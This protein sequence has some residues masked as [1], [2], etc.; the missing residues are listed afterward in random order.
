MFG[1]MA[2][3]Q[4]T[5]VTTFE[6]KSGSQTK[7]VD[8]RH[9]VPANNPAT[10][11]TDG[12]GLPDQWEVANFGHL[13]VDPS[14]D[15]DGDGV[16]NLNEYKNGTDPN[17]YYNG[18]QIQLTIVGGNNQ[19]ANSGQFNSQPFEVMV[20]NGAGTVLLGNAPVTFTVIQG[21]G[22]LA[23]ANTNTSPLSTERTLRTTADGI[24]QIFY[25]QPSTPNVPSQIRAA[26][27]MA[28]AEF[29]TQSRA[30]VEAFYSTDFEA[31][32]GYTLGALSGQQG[33]VVYNNPADVTATDFYSGAQSVVLP[34]GT[35][36]SFVV[37]TLPTPSSASEPIVF[38]DFY[39]KLAAA[40]DLDSAVAFMTDSAWAVL[41][42]VGDRGEIYVF[43]GDGDQI[44]VGWMAT[45]FTVPLSA[46]NQTAQWLHLTVR[47]NFAAQI[48]DLYVNGRM[49]AANVLSNNGSAQQLT[50]FVITGHTTAAVYLDHLRASYDNPLFVDADKDG[51]DDA[52]EAAH[53]LDPT[54]NDRDLDSD[55]DGLTNSQEFMLGTAPDKADTDGDGMSDRWEVTHGLNPIDP[56]DAALDRDGNGQ[57]NLD[58]YRAATLLPPDAPGNL[59]IVSQTATQLTLAWDA[60]EPAPNR[61]IV[62]Y[63]VYL[64]GGKICSTPAL[65]SAVAYDPMGDSLQYY[66]VCAVDDDGRVSAPS[67]EI[68]AARASDPWNVDIQAKYASSG[69]TKNGGVALP[70]NRVFYADAYSL[71]ST[72]DEYSDQGQTG[73]FENHLSITEEYD[74]TNNQWNS[75][76]T[77]A[78]DGWRTKGNQIYDTGT[79]HSDWE[80]D[81]GNNQAIL[82]GED[83]VQDN[84]PL[85]SAHA[86]SFPNPQETDGPTGISI[87]GTYTD[88]GDVYLFPGVTFQ[89]TETSSVSYTKEYTDDQVV[90]KAMD[91]YRAAQGAV[92]GLPWPAWGWDVVANAEN[93]TVISAGAVQF[94]DGRPQYLASYQDDRNRQ[95]H[96]YSVG[97]QGAFYRLHTDNPGPVRFRWLEVFHPWHSEPDGPV[98]DGPPQSVLREETVAGGA[99]GAHTADYSLPP[100][101]SRGGIDI[102]VL[103]ADMVIQTPSMTPTVGAPRLFQ[104]NAI[105]VG[106]VAQI[107]AQ[108]VNWWNTATAGLALAGDMSCISL[109]VVDPQVV[110]SQ[111]MVAALAQGHQV[112]SGANLLTDSIWMN[113]GILAAVGL[114]PGTVDIAITLSIDGNSFPLHKTLSVYPKIE[115]AVDANRDGQ[116]KLSSEDDSDKTSADKPYRFWLN[117]DDDHGTSTTASLGEEHVPIVRPDYTANVISSQ[118]DLED[119]SRLWLEIRAISTALQPKADGTADLYIGLQWTSVTRGAPA[120]KLFRHLEPNG[121]TQYLTDP[122]VAQ[123]Q[124][125]GQAIIDAR[126]ASDDPASSSHSIVNGTATDITFFVLPSSVFANLAGA[127]SVVHFL[128]EGCSVGKGQLQVVILDKNMHIIGCGPGM[129]LDLANIRSMYERAIATA[130]NTVSANGIDCTIPFPHDYTG[131][132]NNDIPRPV[133]GWKAYDLGYPFQ[134]DPNE[135]LQR[136]T[137]VVF[138]HGWRKPP[139]DFVNMAETTFKRMWQSGYKGRFA[140]FRWPT[141]YDNF[142]LGGLFTYNDSEYRAWKCGESLKQYVNQLPSGYTRDV[143]AHSLG[144]IVV[145]SALQRG[146]S[147]ANY[148]L[149]NA[150]VPAMCYDESAELRW[151]TYTTPNDDPDPGTKALAYSGQFKMLNTNVVNFYLPLDSVAG[152][153]WDFNNRQ[154]K[155]QRYDG[156]LGYG[157][158][159]YAYD[160]SEPAGRRLSINFLFA[161]GRYLIDPHEA[162]P[163]AVQSLTRTVGVDG[164]TSGSVRWAVPLDTWNFG[165]QHSAE[166]DRNLQETALFYDEL[167]FRINIFTQ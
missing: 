65:T 55:N 91:G 130:D 118:R 28:Q 49:I 140:A 29:S 148:A 100:P 165:D 11:D 155:P 137:Y 95:G 101:S 158:T 103:S 30:A 79:F 87:T 78:Q 147:V 59:R 124:A 17:D 45:G 69:C 18:Q 74:P 53:G 41:K 8:L 141:F 93:G 38:C 32:E 77:G 68:A 70:Y 153:D 67:N 47:M 85:P 109:V 60:A 16:T 26:A 50:A 131:P 117:D 13:G 128:W 105:F 121:G 83:Y 102:T 66:S 46:N 75:V 125:F 12:N 96:L 120:I 15:P 145:G 116:I 151:W 72:Y 88:S 144:N 152:I 134:P 107:T 90:A 19:S 39:A 110:A 81:R 162:M 126:Y 4:T 112:A 82:V 21:G 25:K 98:D 1:V 136:K 27:A 40:Q 160:P 143:V 106:E 86:P 7:S 22:Q 159:G 9:S 132:D 138:V 142:P 111:G 146:M 2:S 48:W 97:A 167:M 76:V 108:N 135:D 23:S 62:S 129:W 14:A 164:T 157:L 24:A 42:K 115:L 6:V 84:R 113:D 149:L 163:Y 139:E 166:W 58:E 92:A 123:Q 63:D 71:N 31:A 3:A 54:R 73:H 44:G 104:K 20:R 154:F 150:A 52:W 35:P 33:W 99:D 36:P 61:K 5:N 161:F 114:T 94:Y 34:A 89:S 64:N 127:T 51:M 37:T 156:A 43:D 133:M 56:S 80:L 10:L 122:T 119:F 57:T